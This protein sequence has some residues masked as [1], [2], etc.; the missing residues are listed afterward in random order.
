MPKP[1]RLIHWKE[2]LMDTLLIID[3]KPQSSHNEAILER[4]NPARKVMP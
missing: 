4:R 1:V 3:N 2:S